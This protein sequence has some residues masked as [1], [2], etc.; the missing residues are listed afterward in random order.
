MLAILGNE[1]AE[2]IAK[3]SAEN[4]NGHD[5]HSNTDA[6]PHS[7]IF[8]LARVAYQILL[9]PADQGLQQKGSSFTQI[10]ML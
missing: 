5:I 4:Q 6:H 3:G 2:A 1:C 10:L 7:S 9:T 8:W